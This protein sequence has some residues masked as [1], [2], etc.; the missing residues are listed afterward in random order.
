M[1]MNHQ[2]HFIHEA[3]DNLSESQRIHM[4]N[5]L[6]YVTE[7][8]L[9]DIAG[10]KGPRQNSVWWVKNCFRNALSLF[11]TGGRSLATPQTMDV[12]VSTMYAARSVALKVQAVEVC[13]MLSN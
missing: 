10:T 2:S 3:A 1:I 13:D 12:N 11:C 8:T 4:G 9:A 7:Y 6:C 5:F